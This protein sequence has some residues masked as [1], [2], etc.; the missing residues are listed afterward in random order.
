MTKMIPSLVAAVLAALVMVA[1]GGTPGIA[2]QGD[3]TGSGPAKILIQNHANQSIYYVYM[4]PAGE[5]SWGD[6][7]LGSNVLA[8]GQT[9]ELTGLTPGTFSIRV[10]DSGGHY[11]E[12]HEQVLEAG[13][14]YVLEVDAVGWSH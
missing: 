5:R 11:K 1:C 13:G 2:R 9:H 10:A 8:R 6:D 3:P 4:S 14:T 12:W 7:L